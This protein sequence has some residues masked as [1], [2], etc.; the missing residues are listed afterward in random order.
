MLLAVAGACHLT[1]LRRA[2]RRSA[3]QDDFLQLK[4]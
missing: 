4:D 3:I 1:D 2:F